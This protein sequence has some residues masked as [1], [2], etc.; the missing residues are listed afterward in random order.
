[1]SPVR[2][3]DT[4]LQSKSD[5]PRLVLA[6]VECPIPGWWVGQ[7][8]LAGLETALALVSDHCPAVRSHGSVCDVRLGFQHSRTVGE[9][10]R[11]TSQ[12]EDLGQGVLAVPG[13]GSDEDA[14]VVD[15][16]GLDH[17]VDQPGVAAA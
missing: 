10:E 5:D 15:L 8:F 4:F 12:V 14:G 1:M 2:P 3:W 17:R 9:C 6:L 7:R 16:S 11:L 13:P